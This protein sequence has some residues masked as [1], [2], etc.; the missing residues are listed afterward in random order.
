MLFDRNGV[1]LHEFRASDTE[2]KLEWCNL[3]EISIALIK[4]VLLSEDKNFFSH[5]G[6]DWTALSKASLDF[7]IF[8]G[9]RGASTISMQ[10]ATILKSDIEW[11][12][13]RKSIFQ[14]IK[15]IHLAKELEETW[16]KNEILEAYLNL[17]SFRGELVGV[18]AASKG[19]F[20][21]HPHGLNEIESIILSVLI[22][23]PNSNI[24]KIIKRSC[25]VSEKVSPEIS[26][27]EITEKVKI[28]F[29]KK[30]NIE[31]ETL[32]AFHVTRKL[33]EMSHDVYSKYLQ[34]SL[35]F[36]IQKTSNEILQRHLISLQTK[37]V[38]DGAI[39]VV[40]NSTGDVLAYIGSSGRFSTSPE[41]DAVFSKRQAGS[42][43]K[44]FLYALA[45]DKKIIS[46]ET[47]LED[48]P[49]D[50]S[51]YSGIYRPSN[52]E[53]DY[54]GM[55]TAS[56]A[57]ASSLNVPAVRV[58]NLVG[59]DSFFQILSFLKFRD[60]E[61]P[62]F[63]GSSL[64][65]GSLDVTLWDLTNAY[66]TLANGGVYSEIHLSDTSKKIDRKRIFSEGSS[67]TI[68]EIL[69]D[70]EY[71]SLTFG[72]ENSLSSRFSA[73]VKTGTSKDMRDNWCIGFSDKF[74]VG[75]WVGNFSGEPMWNVSGVTG[76]APIWKELIDWL[77]EKYSKDTKKYFVDKTM[78]ENE[79]KENFIYSV[80]KNRIRYP[81]DGAIFAADPDI[82]EENQKLIF[83]SEIIS[84][85]I[86]WS[87]N[88]NS[89]NTNNTERAIW[90]LKT[91]RHTLQLIDKKKGILDTV[92]FEVR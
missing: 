15:Q 22:R 23:S 70:R 17:I 56:N 49:I 36:L 38:K 54:H 84:D 86:I 77:E 76:S 48:S 25:S 81:V 91:G 88:G 29:S 89:I 57:L 58:L 46:S 80:N 28:S 75:V 30:Y 19:L 4:A 45:F 50:I 16:T 72:L 32:Y 47:L 82:P 52:Y 68:K 12:G 65:L 43:L 1:I 37:N 67:L 87:L 73:S 79:H 51:T 71:R 64:A 21:K 31:K 24:E 34:S 59:V 5:N 20:G 41:V 39:L 35:D 3:S 14:K 78:K 40:E 83:E 8:R 42:T 85:N 44:P 66:R 2:R 11:K 7:F 9:K 18:A 53:K 10:L 13:K 60:L 69:A 62:S 33:K 74:T 61:Y 55:V 63:Y 90:T 26:C 27:E 92:H 6:V